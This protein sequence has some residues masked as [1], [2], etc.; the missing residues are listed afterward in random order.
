MRRSLG[1]LQRATTT[2][3][4]MMPPSGIPTRSMDW[5]A[6]RARVRA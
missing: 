6:E 2:W 1:D 5:K 4:K 3:L